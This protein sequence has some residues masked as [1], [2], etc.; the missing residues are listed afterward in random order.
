M[1][2]R[3]QR[4][5][6]RRRRSDYRR[7]VT[8]RMEHSIP[9]LRGDEVVIN[10]ALVTASIY[11]AKEARRA[12]PPDPVNDGLLALSIVLDHVKPMDLKCKNGHLM[13]G[14][15]VIQ[16]QRGTRCRA[17]REN[18]RCKNGHL[19]VGRNEVQTPSG[20]PR[21]RACLNAAKRRHRQVACSA[22][23]RGGS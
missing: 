5:Y 23:D 1:L 10:E 20:I 15:N 14:R 11:A 3:E 7:G 12:T 19:M 4:E 18:L 9:S 2:S 8:D 13:V 6:I 21:C 22:T 17:C 16:M